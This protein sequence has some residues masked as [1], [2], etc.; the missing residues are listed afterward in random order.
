ML[1]RRARRAA[2]RDMMDEPEILLYFQRL[3]CRRT[4]S[5]RIVVAVHRPGRCSC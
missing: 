2:K 5:R 4:G 1:L 3:S